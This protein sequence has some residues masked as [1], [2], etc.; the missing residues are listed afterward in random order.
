MGEQ[1]RIN[2]EWIRR[3]GIITRGIMEGGMAAS[4]MW[5]LVTAGYTIIVY[6]IV[7]G[8]DTA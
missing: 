6:K 2:K 1:G 8:V 4:G 5:E 3:R 7:I